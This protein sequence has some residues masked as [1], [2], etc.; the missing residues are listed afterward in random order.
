MPYR[1]GRFGFGLS[2]DREQAYSRNGLRESICGP[3]RRLTEP[4]AA[5]RERLKSRHL[6]APAARKLLHNLSELGI[7][8][9]QWTH[10]TWDT[11]Y[12]RSAFRFVHTQMGSRFFSEMRVWP[13]KQTA[14]HIILTCPTDRAPREIM[15]L[16]VLDDEQGAGSTPSLAS[17]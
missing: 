3:V 2:F 13:S 6:F 16:T 4:Q 14:D 10:L 7:H 15:G 17:I 1:L 12:W 9:A 8:A 11:E 5:S